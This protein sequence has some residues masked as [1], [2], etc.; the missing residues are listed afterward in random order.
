[1]QHENGCPNLLF[2]TAHTAFDEICVE[3]YADSYSVN[4]VALTSPFKESPNPRLLSLEMSAVETP[5]AV[6]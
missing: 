5:T 4:C 2:A 6:V 3:A 1:M